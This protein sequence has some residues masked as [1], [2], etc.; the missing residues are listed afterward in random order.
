MALFLLIR[1]FRLSFLCRIAGT[2]EEALRA[3]LAQREQ[4]LA[5]LAS[6]LGS[7]QTRAAE[8]RRRSSQS[9]DEQCRSMMEAA[10]RAQPLLHQLSE[11]GATA[12]ICRR[13]E[14]PDSAPASGGPAGSEENCQ[15]RAARSN[16]ACDGPEAEQRDKAHLQEQELQPEPEVC[17]HDTAE[18]DQ[19]VPSAPAEPSDTAAT[20]PDEGTSGVQ[21]GFQ[22]PSRESMQT[23]AAAP[24]MLLSVPG[25]NGRGG[26]DVG[27]SAQAL[28]LAEDAEDLRLELAQRT[29]QAAGLQSRVD[30]L[31]A[32]QSEHERSEASQAAQLAAQSEVSLPAERM[33][34]K[35]T[36]NLSCRKLR[37]ALPQL[38]TTCW[39]PDHR[40]GAYHIK[41][42]LNSGDGLQ[43]LQRLS[44]QLRELQIVSR[45][46]IE[47]ASSALNIPVHADSRADLAVDQLVDN[48]VLQLQVILTLI[49]CNLLV[50]GL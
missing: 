44:H 5:E 39:Y 2:A 13:R 29:A 43:E 9:A 40:L 48:L 16:P 46:A 3:R 42:D 31:M 23:A 45:R 10:T 18:V 22:R 37:I 11:D 50:A 8:T 41:T 1:G 35:G 12:V 6:A 25:G 7:M 26:Y 33:G 20:A 27:V 32:C 19:Q 21:P 4:R 38:W 15:A 36:I 34:K 17:Q 30:H 49:F 47:T 14:A 28:R 24:I